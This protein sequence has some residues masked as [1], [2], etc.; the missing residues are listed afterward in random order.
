[1]AGSASS[2]PVGAV[3]FVDADLNELVGIVGIFGPFRGVEPVESLLAPGGI[4][5]FFEHFMPPLVRPFQML[6]HGVQRVDGSQRGQIL[7]L[8]R[9]AAR[10]VIGRDPDGTRPEY[11]LLWQR[12]SQLKRVTADW[13]SIS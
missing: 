10:T 3:I 7:Q 4:V 13:S 12:L 1:M 5:E 9:D 2:V 11:A 6:R 8:A